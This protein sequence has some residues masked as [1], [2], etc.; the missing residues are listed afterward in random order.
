MSIN[1]FMTIIFDKCNNATFFYFYSYSKQEYLFLSLSLSLSL[2]RKFHFLQFWPKFTE[3][4][5][6]KI[7][8]ISKSMFLF[9]IWVIKN[10]RT[11][12]CNFLDICH[13]MTVDTVLKSIW[14]VLSDAIKSN[15]CYVFVDSTNT[16]AQQKNTCQTRKDYG[17]CKVARAVTT[18]QQLL[19]FCCLYKHESMTKK[20]HSACSGDLF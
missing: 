4:H 20:Q 12:R 11:L 19:R 16:K 15:S 2:S 7:Q 3:F 13:T 1:F 10:K 18:K 17:S 6:F 9:R 5:V 8:W 14:I